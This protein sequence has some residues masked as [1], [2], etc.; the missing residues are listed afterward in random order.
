MK[1]FVNELK[2]ALW[3][4]LE[5]YL[6]EE[7]YIDSGRLEPGFEFNIALAKAICSSVCM[8]VVYVPKYRRHSYCLREY[9]AMEKIEAMRK[10]LLGDEY[11]SEYGMIIPVLLRG[12]KKKLPPKIASHRHFCD[13]SK[14][15]TAVSSIRRNEE[16]VE[17]IEAMARYIAEIYEECRT[18]GKD[19]CGSCDAF[20]MPTEEEVRGWSLQGASTKRQLPLHEEGK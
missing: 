19:L 4:C 9:T 6:D 2:D 7:V 15:T 20:E 1:G 11:K 17:K 5:P 16:Y 10:E 3:D 18:S 12:D 13:F 14:F 8:I